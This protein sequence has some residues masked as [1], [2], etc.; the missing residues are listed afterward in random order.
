MLTLTCL[1]GQVHLE[2]VS[3][4]DYVNACN[5]T[6]C[7]KTGAQWAYFHPS[8]VTVSGATSSYS[9]EDKAEPNACVHFC[10]TCGATTHFRLTDRVIARFGDTMMGVNLALAE[11]DGLR[12][13]EL[14]FPDGRAWPGVGEFTYVREHQ[15]IGGG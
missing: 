3:P 2:L 12:G 1:C 7:S 6:L 9:R 15:V 4:P 8:E 14:R 5:C 10:P 11:P 13:I